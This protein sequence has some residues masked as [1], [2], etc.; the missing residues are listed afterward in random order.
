MTIVAAVILASLVCQVTSA[1]LAFPWVLGITFVITVV[2][3]A[4]AVR[5]LLNQVERMGV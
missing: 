2:R 3:A 4:L 1:A 5:D